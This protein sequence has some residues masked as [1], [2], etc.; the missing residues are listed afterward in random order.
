MS[1][2]CTFSSSLNFHPVKAIP[3]TNTN[4][5]VHLMEVLKFT[6]LRKVIQTD[7]EYKQI[8]TE[9][10]KYSVGG[11]FTC[12]KIDKWFGSKDGGVSQLCVPPL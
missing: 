10:I 4:M 12:F 1:I 9:V 8:N 5:W 7:S 6:V 3:S 11:L 2:V